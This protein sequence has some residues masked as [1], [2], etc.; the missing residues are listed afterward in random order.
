MNRV[1]IHRQNHPDWLA[2]AARRPL[3]QPTAEHPLIIS[4]SEMSTFL[5]CRVR[6]HWSYQ[7]GLESKAISIPRNMG[8]LGHT[9]LQQWYT[10]P[11]HLR[12]LKSMKTLVKPLLRSTDMRVL[13][14]KDRDTLMAMML[15]YALWAR[16]RQT[17]HNDKKIGLQQCEPEK[18]FE[19]P[20]I[21]DRSI[22]VRGKLDNVFTS[23]TYKS[24]VGCLESKLKGQIRYDMVEMNLQLSFYLWAMWKLQPKKKRYIAYYQI[25][26]RQMPSPRVKSDLFH[27]EPVE[28][29]EEEIAQWATDTVHAAHD[30]LDGAIYPH[31]I[32]ACS[33]DCDFRVPCLLRGNAAD[34]LHV[35][36]TEYTL[37][38]RSH[39]A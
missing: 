28:R 15:G 25:L 2:S 26:R 20:L 33:W 19:L 37:R 23:A 3:K 6:H 5:R 18:F 17:E 21:P 32:D 24:T 39:H 16:S 14:T 35:L 9:I 36:Q 11:Y 13:E 38:N 8:T 30:L 1:S 4:T 10:L 27:R 22:L 31:P 7:C 34:V 12:T 29:S